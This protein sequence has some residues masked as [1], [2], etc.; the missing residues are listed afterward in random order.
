MTRTCT[1]RSAW[2]WRWRR[3]HRRQRHDA[4]NPDPNQTSELVEF[5][6]GGKFVGEFSLD[7]NAGGAFGLAVTETGGTVRLAAV[8][9]NTNS[10]DVWTFQT[11]GK[12]TPHGHNAVLSSPAPAVLTSTSTG[13]GSQSQAGTS[14][15]PMASQASSPQ[16][17]PVTP[18]GTTDSS[19]GASTSSSAPATSRNRKGV[20]PIAVALG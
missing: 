14:A 20:D 2:R 18:M 1:G 8:D 10:L 15:G 16:Q 11:G 6:P 13:A 3:P 5:T 12:S 19:A 7:P 9:D 17:A 4:V